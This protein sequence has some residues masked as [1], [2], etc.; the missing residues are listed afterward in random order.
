MLDTKLRSK[1]AHKKAKPTN[2]KSFKVK[3][4]INSFM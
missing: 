1:D 2:G 4:I 3:S